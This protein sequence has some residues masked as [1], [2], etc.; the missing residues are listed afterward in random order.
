MAGD[1]VIRMAPPDDDAKRA[2]LLSCNMRL[3]E[4]PPDVACT[5]HK[6]MMDIKSRDEAHQPP[7]STYYIKKRD[8]V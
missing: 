8:K 1:D 5:Y 7:T 2:A 6:D 4:I 3:D